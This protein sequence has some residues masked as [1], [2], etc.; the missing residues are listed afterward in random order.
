MRSYSYA[1]DLEIV[2]FYADLEEHFFSCH[3]ILWVKLKLVVNWR[4]SFTG[5]S[6]ARSSFNTTMYTAQVCIAWQHYTDPI[7][8][9]MRN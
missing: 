6:T 2:S 4:K 7:R 8:Q 9:R 1:F 5:P 3:N